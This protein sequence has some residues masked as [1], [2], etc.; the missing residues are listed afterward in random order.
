MGP[1]RGGRAHNLDGEANGK[2]LGHIGRPGVLSPRRCKQPH[3]EG[4]ENLPEIESLMIGS[5]ICPRWPPCYP[6]QEGMFYQDV[7]LG[8][9]GVPGGGSLS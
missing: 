6:R 5:F 1:P 7:Y 9:S 4:V 2:N 3:F 8:P